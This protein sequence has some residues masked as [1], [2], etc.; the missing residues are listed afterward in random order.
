MF[1]EFK[2]F[3]MKGNVLDMAIGVIMGGAFGKIVDGLVADVIM[4]VVGGMTGGMDFKDLFIN[5][6]QGAEYASL[7][8]AKKAGAP[9][10]AYGSWL[11]S[12]INFLIIAFVMFMIIKVMKRLKH[13]EPE[14]PSGP[15]QE[16]LLTEIR[17]LLSKK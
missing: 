13:E 3:A 14:A 12:V 16:Q 6:K 10:V 17:D 4:P 5:L 1:K 9:V 7:D 11:N 2:E 15:S 8:A